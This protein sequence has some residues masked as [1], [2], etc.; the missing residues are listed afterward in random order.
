MWCNGMRVKRYDKKAAEK[1]NERYHL[2]NSNSYFDNLALAL[3][4]LSNIS[5]LVVFEL[6]HDYITVI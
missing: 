6:I 3:L 2:H 5:T 4:T 1:L